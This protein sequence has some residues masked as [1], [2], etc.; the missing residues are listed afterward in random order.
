[1]PPR[2]LKLFN[3]LPP[4]GQQ[5]L[6]EKHLANALDSMAKEKSDDSALTYSHYNG[7]LFE[8]ITN[9]PICRDKSA[10]SI[11]ECPEAGITEEAAANHHAHGRI[12]SRCQN[13]LY[14]GTKQ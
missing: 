4:E 6:I 1:M 2:F 8:F 14:K 11:F 12:G 5:M 13:L 3:E 7:T 10:N 9:S